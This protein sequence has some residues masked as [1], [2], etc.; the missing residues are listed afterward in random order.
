M[1]FKVDKPTVY[2]E[3]NYTYTMVVSKT[4]IIIEKNILNLIMTTVI[5][6]LY[7]AVHKLKILGSFSPQ[8]L[9]EA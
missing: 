2:W 9:T 5:S 7:K 1:K 4:A 6:P 8:L 3:N